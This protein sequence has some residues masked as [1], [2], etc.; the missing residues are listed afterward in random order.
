MKR[1][2]VRLWRKSLDGGLLRRHKIWVFFTY[3]LLKAT[4]RRV[5]VVVGCQ[6]IILEPG[7]FIFGRRVASEETGLTER[8]IRTCCRSLATLKILT[9]KTT[10][11]FSIITF[12]NWPTY[13]AP[14]DENDQQ[15]D[16]VPTS[17]RPHTRT[18]ESLKTLRRASVE[19]D[20]TPSEYGGNG[21]KVSKKFDPEG[22]EIRL[23]RTLLDAI[24]SN[25]PTF[26]EP[27]LQ[28]WARDVD[29]ML[30]ID[31]RTPAEIE[32]MIHFA[33]GHN[34]WFKNILSTSSLREKFD[35]LSMEM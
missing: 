19:S 12:V 28:T 8:E 34:F 2:Y 30:R 25:K 10:N 20:A 29:L 35:R 4:H 14:E 7:Q 1:G 9:S 15:N 18:R 26:R 3:C 24:R 16:Q 11:K 22:V 27:N 5:K 17:K 6:E 31:K 33:Q 13:Q 23:S 21:K 32:D